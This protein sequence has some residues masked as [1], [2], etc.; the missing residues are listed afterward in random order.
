MQ[1]SVEGHGTVS[2]SPLPYSTAEM[3]KRISI[4]ESKM[5]SRKASIF[6]FI[7]PIGPQIK[8]E[9]K[10]FPEHMMSAHEVLLKTEEINHILDEAE[11]WLNN[12]VCNEY[13]NDHLEEFRA[14]L[15][16][17][18]DPSAMYA[19]CSTVRVIAIGVGGNMAK[20]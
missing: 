19:I 18:G 16:K 8:P 14:W 3:Q 20:E 7:Y 1:L 5:E 4:A 10:I 9:Q 13:T 12:Q 6:A 15:V 17:G 2:F 11:K